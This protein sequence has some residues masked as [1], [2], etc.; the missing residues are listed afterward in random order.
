MQEQNTL[1]EQELL[2]DE[3]ETWKQ[4]NCTR[5]KCLSYLFLC[6]EKGVNRQVCGALEEIG[7]I[8]TLLAELWKRVE[9]HARKPTVHSSQVGHM[10]L[11]GNNTLATRWMQQ[12]VLPLVLSAQVND[13]DMQ[14]E[15]KNSS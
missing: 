10:P 15:M 1:E 8:E 5:Q 9:I 4:L 11:K 7:E 12:V 6:N 2:S 14:E 13:M 3:E